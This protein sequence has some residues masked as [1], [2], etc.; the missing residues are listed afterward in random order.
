VNGDWTMKDMVAHQ[1][2]WNHWQVDR[3]QAALNGEPEPPSPWPTELQTDDDINAWIYQ[4][5]RKRTVQDVLEETRQVLRQL[6][7]IVEDLPDEA[8]IERLDPDHYLVWLGEER[9]M[10]SEFFNHYYEDHEA[11]VRAWLKQ[12]GISKD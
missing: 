12:E 2:G 8:R 4:S 9:Y 3:F 10:A 7:Q 1:T 6:I 11:D 5:Y